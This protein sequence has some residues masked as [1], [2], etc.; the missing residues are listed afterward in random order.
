MNGNQSMLSIEIKFPT[1]ISD[2]GE[3]ARISDALNT[4]DEVYRLLQTPDSVSISGKIDFRKKALKEIDGADLKGFHVN[5][6]FELIINADSLWIGAIIYVIKNYS[7]LKE[8]TLE[9]LDDMDDLSDFVEGITKDQVDYIKYS[10]SVFVENMSSLA[11]DERN[12]WTKKI[13]MAKSRLMGLSE[14][15]RITIKK[16]END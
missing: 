8:N 12:R 16:N 11:E 14:N 4:V 2:V 7:S 6:P 3:L 13:E 15:I 10:I 9:F 1:I 5:S